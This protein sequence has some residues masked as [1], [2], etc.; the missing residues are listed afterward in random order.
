MGNPIA[1]PLPFQERTYWCWAAVSKGVADWYFQGNSQYRQ[2]SIATSVLNVGDCC[3]GAPC[4]KIYDLDKALAA[5][6]HYSGE[7]QYYSSQGPFDMAQQSIQ[8]EIDA[9][10]PLG[11]KITW[12]DGSGHFVVVC[13]YSFSD[14][15]N[16]TLYVADPECSSP[17]CPGVP[18]MMSVDFYVFFSN[19]NGHG[20]CTALYLTK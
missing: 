4:N 5:V 1:L 20:G 6:G 10:R 14:V 13:G 18:Q 11:A 2:C 16:S 12:R 19:Y 17:P 8:T 3:N 15:N 7:T 9:G